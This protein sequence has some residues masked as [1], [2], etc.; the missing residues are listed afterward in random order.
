M[1]GDSFSDRKPPDVISDHPSMSDPDLISFDSEVP[2]PSK[3]IGADSQSLDSA[4]FTLYEGDTV[5]SFKVPKGKALESGV[6]LQSG[7][8]LTSSCSTL[9]GDRSD[10][11]QHVRFVDG[12]CLVKLCFQ[13][14]IESNE[15]FFNCAFVVRFFAMETVFKQN[16]WYTTKQS[17]LRSHRICL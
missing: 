1:D 13:F 14:I 2:L 4:A 6:A 17:Q 15:I 8:S 16:H 7:G 9:V 12:T 11:Q 10:A 3:P 5:G